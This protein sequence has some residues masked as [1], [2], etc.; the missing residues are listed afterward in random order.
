MVV[1]SGESGIAIL[2]FYYN[3]LTVLVLGLGHI[4]YNNHT[5]H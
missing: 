3:K 5:M 2:R 1:L 4:H